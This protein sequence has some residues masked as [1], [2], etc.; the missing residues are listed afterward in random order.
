[1]HILVVDDEPSMRDVLEVLFTRAGFQVTCA[2]SVRDASA[3][4]AKAPVDL[5]LTDMKL[6]SGSGMEVLRSARALKDAP[7]VIVITAFGTAASAVEAMREGA[8][9]YI[10]KPFDNEELRLLV[11]KALEKRTLRQENL[12]LRAQLLPGA[13]ML[14][15]GRSARMQTVMGLVEKVA[16]TRTTVLIYGESGTGKELIA[17]ALHLRSPRA[18]HPFLPV[19]CAALSEGVLESELFGHVKGAFTGATSDRAGLL[20]A[21]GEGTVLLDEIGEVPPATQV[22]L[23]RVLQERKVKPVG[24]S[25]E[26][27]FQARLVAATNRNLDAEVKA[28]R[29][30]EDLLYRLNVITLELPPL[31]ERAEDI[32]LLARHFLARLVE[33]VGRPGLHFTPEALDILQRYPWPGNVRQLQNIVERAVA[34]SDGDA[35]GPD[36]LPATLRGEPTAPTGDVQLPAGFNLERFLDDSERRYLLAA[37]K[38]TDGVKTRAAELLGLSFRSFRYRLAKHGLVDEL[39]E[40]RES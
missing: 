39:D 36:T 35:L 29:F 7:E 37:L 23:L 3:A 13:G 28:G 17:R 38:R 6:G 27:P 12:T 15:V 30:R 24:S 8:Y 34:L 16:S 32:P 5:V 33:E 11:Q 2:G 9:H 21:A 1:M 22:K 10:C 20:A 18:G 31:R 26:V 25:Q 40:V 19:N 4:L 14:A